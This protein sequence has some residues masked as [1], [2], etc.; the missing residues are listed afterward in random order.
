MFRLL[1]LPQELIDVII[2]FALVAERPV[3]TSIPL[4]ASEAGR[5]SHFGSGGVY[6]AW[7]YG[8]ANIMWDQKSQTTPNAVPLLLVN[9]MFAS[10]TRRAVELLVASNRLVY[11]LDVV[12]VDEREL[13]PTWTSVPVICPVVDRLAVTIR[14]FGADSDLR[15]NETEPTPRQRKFWA[16]SPGHNSPPKLVW[17]FFY[18][19]QHILCN[20]PSTRAKQISPLVIRHAIV[21]IMPFPGSPDQLDGASDDEWM[22]AR[23]RRQGNVSNPPQPISE[24]DNLLRAVSMRPAFLKIFMARQLSGF[25]HMTFFAPP[26]L[27]ILH[28]Q[29]GQITLA[30]SDDERAYI[31][32]GLILAELDVPRYGPPGI[33]AQWKANVLQVR[34]EHGFD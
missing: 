27:R 15:G 23:E 21:N 25:F 6:S 32:P 31:D 5:S 24:Q 10:A 7:D 18:L 16:L 4:E 12:L 26:T 13:W 30:S 3:P 34:A 29:L 1:D 9:R 19:F 28:L 17:C 11:K 22:S 20:G 8:V 14:I 2:S 33:F